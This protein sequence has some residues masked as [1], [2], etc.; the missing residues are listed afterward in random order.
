VDDRPPYDAPRRAGRVRAVLERV[1]AE[2]RA[3]DET[4]TAGAPAA[5]GAQRRSGSFGGA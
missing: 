3:V 2:E 1:V 4:K 5:R